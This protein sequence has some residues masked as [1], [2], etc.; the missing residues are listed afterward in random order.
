VNTVGINEKAARALR[1]AVL[2]AA[3]IMAVATVPAHGAGTIDYPD[4]TSTVGLTLSG[5]AIKS[6]AVL[7]LSSAGDSAVGSAFA[8]TAFEPSQPF[9][10]EFTLRTQ[11]GAEPAAGMS[12]ILERSPDGV[13]AQERMGPSVTVTFTRA[14]GPFDGYGLAIA[15]APQFG[16]GDGPYFAGIAGHHGDPVAV[17]IDYWPHSGTLQISDADRFPVF[18]RTMD[19]A[20]TLGGP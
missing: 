8:S 5:T 18:S 20:G 19:V 16:G 14:P 12:F 11:G 17:A 6:G 1:R 2:I 4:F 7:R 13:H 10:T 3:A 15:L 9:H